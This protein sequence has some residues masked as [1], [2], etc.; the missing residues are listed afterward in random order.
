[1]TSQKPNLEGPAAWCC[2]LFAAMLIATIPLGGGTPTW[3]MLPA[4]VL[5]IVGLFFARTLTDRW[6]RTSI[7][8]P[9]AIVTA[10]AISLTTCDLPG[11]AIERIVPTFAFVLLIPAVQIACWRPIVIRMIGASACLAVVAINADVVINMILGTP[12]F[13]KD[14]PTSSSRI[15]GSFGNP[16]DLVA[17]SILIP[18]TA[19]SLATS[20]SRVRLAVIPAGIPVWA[21]GLSRQALLGWMIASIS[22]MTPKRRSW[23]TWSIG[24]ALFAAVAALAL[25]NPDAR[26]RVQA[27]FAGETSGRP[28]LI[29]FGLDVFLD[30]PWTGIGPSLFGEY[31]LTAASEGWSWQGRPLKTI[32]MP[33]VHNI[34]LEIL[35]EYGVVGFGI[36]LTVFVDAGRSIRRGLQTHDP[37]RRIA[38][39]S[40][41]TLIVIALVGFV[42]LSL[43]KD[44]FQ[45]ALWT[46]VGLAIA[47]GR[48]KSEIESELS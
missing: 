36:F 7:W 14:T 30:H 12:L 38:V 31:Y 24:L 8:Q 6:S 29:A 41:G 45:I 47:S 40:R 9:V 21:L 34:P 32:G 4:V 23:R 17:S 37:V 5:V 48:M 25:I 26:D 20:Q 2:G 3:V 43:I 44:W 35:I 27:T 22:I 33:W 1:M 16:N 42:D 11:I 18:I 46:S 10:M 15:T 19:L 39:A 28:I 13:P